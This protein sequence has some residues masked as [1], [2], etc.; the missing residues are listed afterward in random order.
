MVVQLDNT[1]S[2]YNSLRMQTS[3][4]MLL[5]KE[6]SWIPHIWLEQ[7]FH[8]MET[9]SADSDDVSVWELVGL[10]PVG[11]RN[12]FE[13]CVENTSNVAQFLFDKWDNLPLCGGS[14]DVHG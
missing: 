10:L 5:E 12:R 8:V 4:F 2:A 13:L 9:F 14:E 11:I 1:T 6:V 7:H 3:L